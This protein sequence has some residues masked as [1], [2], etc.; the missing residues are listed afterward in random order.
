MRSSPCGSTC[1]S[2]RHQLGVHQPPSSQLAPYYEADDFHILSPG[3]PLDLQLPIGR[4]Q[5]PADASMRHLVR[6][7]ASRASYGAGVLRGLLA[8][9]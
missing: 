1:R 3:A 4:I 7:L 2:K 5:Y 9:R 8:G 6:P